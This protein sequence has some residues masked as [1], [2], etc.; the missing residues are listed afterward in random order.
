MEF[1]MTGELSGA[2]SAPV[3]P[4]ARPD[5]RSSTARKLRR[6]QKALARDLKQPLPA[7]DDALLRAASLAIHRVNELEA[8]VTRGDVVDDSAIVP[9]LNAAHRLL[10]SL[11]KR[12]RKSSAPD[13]RAYLQQ[14][15]VI[16]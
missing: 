16:G 3:R 7:A 11:S 6:I 1:K 13:L 5:G 14:R 10:A 15:T 2:P 4:R 9:L 12:S 8:A